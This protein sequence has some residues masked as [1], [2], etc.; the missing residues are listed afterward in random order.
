[1]LYIF[2]AFILYMQSILVLYKRSIFNITFANILLIFIIGGKYYNAWDWVNYQSYFT[3]IYDYSFLDSFNECKDISHF[4]AGFIALIK[5]VQYFG[6]SIN[7]LYILIAI[8]NVLSL[9]FFIKTLKIK[10]WAYIYTAFFLIFSWALWMQALRQ[11]LAFSLVLIGLSLLFRQRTF[12]AIFSF[13]ISLLFH[14]SSIIII[15]FILYFW[16]KGKSRLIL[17]LIFVILAIPFLY[18]SF[19][20][21]YSKF[22]SYTENTAYNA[23]A[24]MSTWLK[25][26]VYLL[27]YYVIKINRNDILH[28]Q[29]NYLLFKL[30]TLGIVLYPIFSLLI[31][32]TRFNLYFMPFAFVL[33]AQINNTRQKLWILNICVCIFISFLSSIN[34][35]VDLLPFNN[36][37]IDRYLLN[38]NFDY[39]EQKYILEQKQYKNDVI[40]E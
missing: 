30:Y 1:M 17:L 27:I 6:F 29:Y 10:Y 34:T 32:T 9:S 4:E 18:L 21:I 20:F 23:V 5:L 26:I 25:Y 24:N 31:I 16:L 15:P 28:N 38:N 22:N 3:C 33:L 39:N 37:F 12:L 35:R 13:I 36:Y 7:I 40:V 8:I 2:T 14:F 19:D 11:G